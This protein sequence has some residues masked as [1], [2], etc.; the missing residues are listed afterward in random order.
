M[1]VHRR[2]LV[3]CT[4]TIRKFPDEL[5][6]LTYRFSTAPNAT[7]AAYRGLVEGRVTIDGFGDIARAVSSLE[8]QYEVSTWSVR[9]LDLDGFFRGL[10]ADPT[11]NGIDQNRWE[12]SAEIVSEEGNAAQLAPI[13]FFTGVVTDATPEA[14]RLFSLQ[15]KCLLGGHLKGFDLDTTLQAP[16]LKDYF[17]ALE[18]FPEALGDQMAA[19]VYGENSD[20]GAQAAGGVAAA[21]GLVAARY[22]GKRLISDGL[23]GTPPTAPVYMAPPSG[24]TVVVD[25]SAD[26]SG[27]TKTMA[28]GISFRTDFGETTT[29]QVIVNDYPVPPF[30]G[31]TATWSWP[32]PADYPD[33]L[34]QVNCWKHEG[35]GTANL[36]MDGPNGNDGE[37]PVETST[38]DDGDDN[39]WLNG[40]HAG[41]VTVNTAQVAPGA[42][43]VR[44]SGPMFFDCYIVAAGVLPF[45]QV[46]FFAANLGDA[47]GPPV[48]TL[49]DASTPNSG[50]RNVEIIA[51]GDVLWPHA[52]NWIEATNPL[53]G[54]TQR[55]T[56]FYMRGERSTQ[57]INGQVG[58]ALNIGGY[59]AN[60]DG[61]GLMFDQAAYVLQHCLENWW[62]LDPDVPH[63]T[64]G[65]TW[66]ATPTFGNGNPKLRTSAF[67][68]FQ[69]DTAT[70][71]GT[72]AG[73]LC[74]F[75]LDQPITLRDF[76]AKWGWTFYAR[77]LV[78]HFGQLAPR[79]NPH[80]L[81]NTGTRFRDRVEVKR[82]LTPT[83]DRNV[84]TQITY[85]F[86]WDAEAQQFRRDPITIPDTPDDLTV[87]NGGRAK[88]RDTIE[89]PYTGDALTAQVSAYYWLELFKKARRFQPIE[90]SLRGLAIDL[91]DPWRLTHYDGL[92]TTG[93][94]DTQM[95][96]D[97]HVISPTR[98]TVTLTGLDLST[99]AVP[100]IPGLSP[101]RDEDDMDAGNLG[102]ETSDAAPP[103]GAYALS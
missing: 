31:R 102:D 26:P 93:E 42:P 101:L 13:S 41:P 36:F 48:R 7:P 52:V 8:G 96:V 85:V 64:N 35:G 75:V 81:S 86:D 95:L 61:T 88:T 27:P 19:I 9:F 34:V 76:L 59:T 94:T 54:L 70:A 37:F 83:I 62:G 68:Q 47:G 24:L 55:F 44:A 60:P 71:M 72:T 90:T 57:A 11:T 89:M 97:R 74:R 46:Q 79:R 84:A 51:P 18:G 99:L 69:T 78:N 25:N 80:S 56:G 33:E 67:T 29:Y 100:N 63:Y 66:N 28:C 21:K 32:A 17:G 20:R 91:G 39:E 23:P 22:V 15:A 4:M 16:T 6:T 53:T 14:G 43:G 5:G 49:L 82:W 30:N 77:L 92:G 58:I 40:W 2:A 3:A 38:V 1:S 103:A 98:Q 45:A 65:D 10:L 50:L 73:A 87:A 12:I